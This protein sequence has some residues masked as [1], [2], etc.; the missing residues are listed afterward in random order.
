MTVA[1]EI[2]VTTTVEH[3]VA[4]LTKCLQ[5]KFDHI[6]F[7]CKDKRRRTKVEAA[8]NA[9]LPDVKHIIYVAPDDI[10]AALEQVDPQPKTTEGTIRGYK[11]K[12]NRS[13]LSAEE[14]AA[15]RKAIMEA[16]ARSLA[17]GEKI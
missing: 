17:K 4:N 14:I 3:E 8:L 1:C 15:K 12:T 2:S 5:T 11:V 10:L 9:E 7:V 13:T 6:I 16:I